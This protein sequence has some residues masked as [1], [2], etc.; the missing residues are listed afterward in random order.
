M[1]KIRN[2]KLILDVTQKPSYKHRIR[3]LFRKLKSILYKIRL[4]RIKINSGERKRY[5]VTICAIFKNE[6]PYL[7]E[8]IEFNRVVGIEHFYLF[9]NNS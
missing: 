3:V 2:S 8:W 9:N 6:A 1:K 5:N 7:R 4:N